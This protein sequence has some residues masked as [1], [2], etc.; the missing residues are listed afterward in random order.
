MSN[1]ELK[2]EILVIAD[3]LRGLASIDEN[4]R[5]VFP[6]D[7]F[8]QTLPEGL[9]TKLIKTVDVS[10][11]NF[12]VA[13]ALVV[14]ELGAEHLK[15]NKDV[16]EITSRINLPTGYTY[17]D[18]KRDYVKRNPTNGELTTVHGWVTTR[19]VNK[20]PGGGLTALRNKCADLA[21]K[22]GLN[23]TKK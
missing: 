22:Y 17:V 23:K 21:D 12:A 7:A 6:N 4:H 18:Y 3:K 10:K 5:V 8:E 2:P 15:K 11:Q 9:S 19:I 20:I 13:Q 16:K 1:K 14:A